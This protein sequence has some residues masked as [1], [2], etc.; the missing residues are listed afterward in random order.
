[1]RGYLL[2]THA[3]IW[4]LAN[5]SKLGKSAK[6]IIENPNNRLYYSPLS[7]CEIAIK[8]SIGKLK[9]VDNWQEIYQ[10]QFIQNDICPLVQTW[11]D[12]AILQSLPFHHRD[13]F[14]RMLISCA[15]ANDL[16]LI[17][18]DGNISLYDLSVI[19]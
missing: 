18:A 15:M 1:M 9:L 17:S 4:M 3:L 8:I 14:D 11:H 12:I 5:P 7:L 10:K 19:W 16:D 6:A 2:D 13:P